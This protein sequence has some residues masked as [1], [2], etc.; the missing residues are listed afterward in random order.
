V[1]PP[2]NQA[3]NGENK[4]QPVISGETGLL[5]SIIF[6]IISPNGEEKKRNADRQSLAIKYFFPNRRYFGYYVWDFM[7]GKA[8]EVL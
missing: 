3:A 6:L 4:P 2:G 5:D 7:K 1:A 8:Q